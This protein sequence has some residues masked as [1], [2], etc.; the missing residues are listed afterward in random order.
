MRKIIG[1]PSFLG[2]SKIANGYY[3]VSDIIYQNIYRKAIFVPTSNNFFGNLSNLYFIN[4][5]FKQ[6]KINIGGDH[7]MSIATIAESLNRFNN[8]KVLWIDA[9]ADIN[10]YDSSPTKNYHGMPLSF[11]TGLDKNKKFKF[12]KNN[13]PLENLF[14]IGLR[15]LDNFEKDIIKKHKIKHLSVNDFNQRNFD[16]VL[17]FLH[18]S[19]VHLSFDV[20]SI[21]PYYIKSTGTPVD[22]GLHLNSMFNFLE[23]LETMDKTNF[24][25]MDLV[26]LNTSIGNKKQVKKSVKNTRKIFNRLMLL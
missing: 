13:L 22:D 5:S 24:Y 16:Q 8:T 17:D 15:D 23:K 18:K 25:N 3:S 2:Q 19:N 20:D 11:L 1:F 9:H 4:S 26:E 21:D 10:T 12:I 7:S 6:P 14:Y